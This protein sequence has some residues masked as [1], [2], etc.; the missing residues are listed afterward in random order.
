MM[1]KG[2]INVTLHNLLKSL[3]KTECRIRHFQMLMRRFFIN[4]TTIIRLCV[5]V[6]YLIASNLH[7]L[8]DKQDAMVES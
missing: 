5:V 7:N 4:T 2:N 1:L 3:I 8:Y 6:V